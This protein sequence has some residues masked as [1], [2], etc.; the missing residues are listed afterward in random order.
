MKGAKPTP[1]GNVVP[2]KGDAT[3][4]APE[5]FEW[6]SELGR[7]VWR[8]LASELARMDRLEI[9]YRHQFASYCEAVSNFIS[10][11]N[12]LAMHGLWYETGKGRNGNQ[13]RKAAALAIQSEAMN[14]MRRDAALFG[15]TPVDESR[16]SSGG[17]GDLFDKLM[18]QLKGGPSA[19]A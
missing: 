1:V 14:H 19:S 9:H 2:M 15:L 6:M 10:S 17:Q 16:I 7:D 4:A 5:P 13:Q 8:E 3:K 18:D 11:T 12:D